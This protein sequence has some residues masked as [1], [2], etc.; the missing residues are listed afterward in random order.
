MGTAM[1]RVRL[2]TMKA[3][4]ENPASA[5]PTRQSSRK[6]RMRTPSKK[7]KLPTTWMTNCEKKLESAVVS[8]STRSIISPGVC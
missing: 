6:T 7:N 8:P 2:K 1:L 3:R 5:V 4:M